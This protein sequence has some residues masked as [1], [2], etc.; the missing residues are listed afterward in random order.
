[1]R[2]E[3]KRLGAIEEMEDGSLVPQR[4]AVV[5]ED[6]ESRVLEGFTF[7]LAP[8]AETIAFNAQ[9]IGKPRFQRVVHSERIDATRVKEVTE[10]VFASLVEFSE[11]LDTELTSFEVPAARDSESKADLGVG[12]YFFIRSEPN[13]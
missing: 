10:T 2:A 7:G 9:A 6:S 13:G 5:P 12:L 1:M 8:L 3:L 11:S 4:R